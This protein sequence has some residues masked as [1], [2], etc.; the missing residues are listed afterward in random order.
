MKKSLLAALLSISLTAYAGDTIEQTMAELVAAR[1]AITNAIVQKGGTVT[2][3]ALTNVPNEILSIPSGGGGSSS[4]K[5]VVARQETPTYDVSVSDLSG[6]TRIGSYAFGYCTGLTS[7]EI[8]NSV[9]N[10]G[11]N[12]FI[13]CTGL[14]SLVIP[15]AVTII[16]AYT[17]RNCSNLATIDFGSTRSTVPT[18]M[19]INAFS[20][21]PNDYRILVPSS[22]LDTWK[23]NASW[24]SIS[25]HIVAHP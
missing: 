3:G 8:P 23:A 13:G 20:G 25:Q 1:D 12:A 14:T 4:L 21:C 15:D 16:N 19:N 22:L 24:S 6:I 17:F 10:I 5:A 2:S 9:T 7:V 11:G 18:L